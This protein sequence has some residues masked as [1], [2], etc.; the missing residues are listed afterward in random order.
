MSD[1]NVARY[2]QRLRAFAVEKEVGKIVRKNKNDIIKLNKDNLS[3]GLNS[4]DQLVGTY[5][6]YTQAWAF[7]KGKEANTLK[8]AGSNYNFNWTGKFIKGI[9]ITYENNKIKFFS[10]GMGLTSKTRFITNNNLLGVSK[11]GAKII[12]E[13]VV[14]PNLQNSF[15]A[16]LNK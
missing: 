12:N 15:K 7:R 1:W 13:D 6:T 2:K 5:S 9:F 4:E 16:H 10:K 8:I 3:K 11:K 14:K